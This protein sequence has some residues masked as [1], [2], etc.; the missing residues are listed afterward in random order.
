MV[1][2]FVAAFATF[3]HVR[4]INGR[5]RKPQCRRCACIDGVAMDVLSL[6]ANHVWKA[7]P[8]CRILVVDSGA[9]RFDYPADWIVRSGTK[10]M[11]LL[12]RYP[13]HEPSY[14]G[15]RWRRIS[16]AEASLPVG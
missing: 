15:L 10:Q 7:T 6:S 5:K 11:L 1:A 13:R 4:T 16:L 2:E 9:V 8:G 12:D 3:R 14:I